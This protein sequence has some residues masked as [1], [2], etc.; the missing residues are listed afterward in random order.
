MSQAVRVL[1]ILL[2][3]REFS[4]GQK[5]LMDLIDSLL[6]GFG[7]S[8]LLNLLIALCVLCQQNKISHIAIL[9]QHLIY[10]TLTL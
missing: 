5:T 3:K 2:I 9:F 4:N 10:H 7:F 8:W 6:T 1:L